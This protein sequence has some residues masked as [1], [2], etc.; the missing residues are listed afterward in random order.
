[1]PRPTSSFRSDS[2][3]HEL[4]P[5]DAHAYIGIARLKPGVIARTSQCRC[6]PHAAD[7]DPRAGHQRERTLTAA[8]FGAALR[9]LK[10]DVIGDVGPVLW[11]L[12]GTIG[13]VL[14]IACANVANL[15]LVRAEGRRQELTLRAAL[16]AGWSHI[17]RH[18]LVESLALALM[19]GALGI[20]A[21]LRGTS[22]PRCDRAGE[23]AALGGDLDR[24]RWYWHSRWLCR[25]CQRCSSG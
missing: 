16:G 7:L 9:P 22:I 2:K 3:A 5:N 17:A 12:M 1:M 14:L 11:L 18:L 8:R 15:L 13:V 24:L 19:G 6:R 20:G 10:Q 25:S 21:R 4:L 23:P